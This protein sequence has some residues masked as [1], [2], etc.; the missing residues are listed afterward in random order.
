MLV[1]F[2]VDGLGV[3]ILAPTMDAGVQMT[4]RSG[5]GRAPIDLQ[6]IV[7]RLW[8]S[9]PLLQRTLFDSQLRHLVAASLVQQEMVAG[10]PGLVLPD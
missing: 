10:G 3:P 7:G 6:T 4:A 1:R 8:M 9:V 5:G 2:Y